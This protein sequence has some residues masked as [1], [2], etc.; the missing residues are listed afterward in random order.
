MCYCCDTNV[1]VHVCMKEWVNANVCVRVYWFAYWYNYIILC[2]DCRIW[3]K[4]FFLKK[5]K[6][7]K[8]ITQDVLDNLRSGQ[9]TDVIIM[10]FAKAFDKVSPWRLGIKLS[11]YGVKGKVNSWIKDFLDPAITASR[12]SR[13]TLWVGPCA[14]WRA[15]RFSHW[16]SPLLGVH[17]WHPGKSEIHSSPICRRHHHVYDGIWGEGC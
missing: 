11:N 2:K 13:R 17:Q 7:S 5:F 14:E 4:V 9:Q 10:D 6:K 12:L 3:I 15:A 16:A 1:Y 8:K